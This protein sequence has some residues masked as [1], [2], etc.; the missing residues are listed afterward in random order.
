MNC[1]KNRKNKENYKVIKI[2]KINFK[3]VLTNMGSI[4]IMKS[5]K[6]T[7]KP[8][9]Q[10]KSE[11]EVL[12]EKENFKKNQI[13]KEVNHNRKEGTVHLTVKVVLFIFHKDLKTISC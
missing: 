10:R 2:W 8:L 11:K 13:F 6:E 5:T 7:K 9:L 1:I 12:D 4:C 3:N